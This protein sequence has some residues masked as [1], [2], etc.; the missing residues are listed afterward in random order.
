MNR[1]S[2]VPPFLPLALALAATI[3]VQFY[4]WPHVTDD[5][6]I[7]FRYAS[8]LASGNGLVF[9]PG[10]H[11]EGFS[12]PLWTLLLGSLFALTG[13]PLPDLARG[14]GVVCALATIIVIYRFWR[15]DLS[16]FGSAPLVLSLFFLILTPGFHVYATAGLEGPLL[17]FL[18]IWGS[19]VSLATSRSSALVAAAAF[20]LVGITRPEGPAYALL[21]FL[22]TVQSDQSIWRMVRKELPRFLVMILPI[23][24]WQIF[25]LFYYGAWLP[26]TAI[27]KV[28]GVFGEFIGLADYITPWLIALGGPL[29]IL[30][31]LLVPP[32]AGGARRLERICI[33]V[34]GATVIFVLYAR[35]DWM[36]FGR[37]IVPVWPLIAVIFSIWLTSGM[38]ALAGATGLR[39]RPLAASLPFLAIAFCSF[40]AWRP[41][42]EEYVGNKNM[43]MLMRGSDQLAVGHWLS[44]NIA[45]HATIATGRLGGISYGAISNV[46]W[47]WFGLTDAEEAEYARKGRPGT[48]ADDPVFRRKPDVIAAIEAPAD[49]SYKRTTQLMNYLEKDY[50]FILSFP[51]GTYGYVDIW[52]RNERLP[53]I[54]LTRDQFVL[55][56]PRKPD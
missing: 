8:H 1:S 34:T 15:R 44:R 43:A 36:P 47:D 55:P 19:Y 17:S 9:N 23:A 21:W 52:I 35:G 11:V 42:V 37:F 2:A 22:A 5:A 33:A 10:E 13:L 49:W 30:V 39:F 51:Q 20:G 12:N 38:K 41:A 27:A 25:R 3:A 16:A 45:P 46:V 48:I 32:P 18:I 56:P 26:N 24:G 53:Q 29:V 6:Y 31:W 4:L 7:S 14:L 40:L 50:Q 28:P 54:F